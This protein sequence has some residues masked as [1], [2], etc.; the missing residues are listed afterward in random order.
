MDLSIEQEQ[1]IGGMT[2]GILAVGNV[3]GG[4]GGSL[5][6]KKLELEEALREKFGYMTR[7]E[8]K[9][10]H[11]M[12]VYA[13]YYRKF[14]YTYHILPQLE[15]VAQGKEIPDV[16]PPVTAMFMAELK[17]MLLTAAHDLDKL[18][19]PLRLVRS[20]G[21]ER[22]PTLSGKDVLTVRDDFMITDRVGVISAILRG[23][24]AR[25][26]ISETTNNVL[27]TVYA[28]PGIDGSLVIR[29]LDDIEDY[30]S[31]FSAAPVTLLKQILGRGC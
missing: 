21:N 12:D 17:N 9:S 7:A 30:I 3:G 23:C 31:L 6:Q 20:T 5:R 18:V 4:D 10:Q 22:M 29:H 16:L 19:P 28:P 26:A 14:G 1:S 27:Y 8:L 15:S 13:A 11:P 24:D 25:T 2:L